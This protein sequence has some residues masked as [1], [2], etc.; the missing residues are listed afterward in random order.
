[1]LKKICNYMNLKLLK[2]AILVLLII[3]VLGFRS[4]NQKSIEGS[5]SILSVENVS[6][7]GTRTIVFPKNSQAIFFNKYYSFCWS[8]DVHNV[9]SWIMTDEVKLDR[10]NKTIVNTGSF[11]FK[12][13]QLITK[14]K[15]ALNPKFIDGVANFEVSYSRDTLVLKCL[16]VISKDNIIH[17][18]YEKSYSITKL[19]KN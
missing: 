19:I 3:I 13:N 5:W 15:Y 16:K 17:P 6:N 10:M 18:F 7:N 2:P 8:S 9:D 1:M 14:A 11:Y 12:N 4:L